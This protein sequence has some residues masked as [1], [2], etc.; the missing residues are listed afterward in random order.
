MGEDSG[1]ALPGDEAKFV[2]TWG[3]RT[4]YDCLTIDIVVNF[5]CVD[6]K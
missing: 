2:F 5:S 6:H 3:G 1:D 4:V